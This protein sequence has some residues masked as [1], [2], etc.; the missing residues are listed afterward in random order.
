MVQE[1]LA[2]FL[3]AA[4]GPTRIQLGEQV[5]LTPEHLAAGILSLDTT[6]GTG[7]GRRN[8]AEHVIEEFVQVGRGNTVFFYTAL[9][10]HA[11]VIAAIDLDMRARE[12][13]S[14]SIRRQDVAGGA[15]ERGPA[16][17]L[18]FDLRECGKLHLL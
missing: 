6:A 5:E 1:D 3:G 14:F 10:N 7:Q 11:M 18:G 12:I 4:G 15:D 17:D 2:L 16:L 13:L 8:R 9:D